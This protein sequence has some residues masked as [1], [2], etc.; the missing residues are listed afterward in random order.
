[1]EMM[2]LMKS[3]HSVRRY[4]E[5]PIAEELRAAINIFIDET[6]LASGLNIRVCYD[7]PRAFQ[8]L[9]AHYGSF[10]NAVN[11]I[12]FVGK[13]EEETK[14]GYF[15]EAIVLKLQELGINTCWVAVSY[16]KRKTPLK[17][18]KDETILCVI[19]FGYG[20][21]QGTMHRSKKVSDISEVIGEKPSWFDAAVEAALLAPTAVNQQKYKIVCEN[22]IVTVR[23]NG[24]GYYV[25][26]DLGIIKYHFEA[27]TGQKAEII[28]V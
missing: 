26:I 10:R 28:S 15:G 7:E 13:K 22:G 2:E 17:I 1:M 25:N 23:P 27:A 4:L 5:K 9:L 6:K 3:R 8:T 19:S 16:S 11:Y 12:A 18:N 14:V 21:T 20:E 24:I